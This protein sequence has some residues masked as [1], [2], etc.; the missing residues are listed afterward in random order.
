LTAWLVSIV[1]AT[2]VGVLVEL[3]L[4]D[5][6]MSKFIRSIYAFFILFVIVQPLPGFF[7]NATANLKNGE[8]PI[9]SGLVAEIDNQT[10]IALAANAETV[11]QQNGFNN[12]I[13][14]YFNG[15]V[16]INAH[17]SAKKD[18]AKIISIVTAVMNVPSNAVEVYI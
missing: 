7:K 5:S 18:E 17:N 15:R 10:K 13:V 4:T 8:V 1:G 11:L 12:C 3:L 9:N 2:V 14:T 6:P 16:Y